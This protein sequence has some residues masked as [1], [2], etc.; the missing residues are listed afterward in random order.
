MFYLYGNTRRLAPKALQFYCIP[1]SMLFVLFFFV[2]R[3]WDNFCR[4]KPTE[5]K[6]FVLQLF[7]NPASL[8]TKKLE[9][10][11]AQRVTVPKLLTLNTCFTL[12]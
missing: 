10:A 6:T 12:T 9:M 5:L 11:K 7:A 2:L 3:S 1:K 4:N 8:A